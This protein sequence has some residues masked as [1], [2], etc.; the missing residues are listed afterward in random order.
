MTVITLLIGLSLFAGLTALVVFI[1]TVS[2]G[3][4]DDAEGDAWRILIDD[5]DPGT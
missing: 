3:Q 2:S 1:W 5:E 4:Y